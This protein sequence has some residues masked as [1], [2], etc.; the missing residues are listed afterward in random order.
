[1]EGGQPSLVSS[2]FQL[3]QVSGNDILVAF[4]DVLQSIDAEQPLAALNETTIT[5]NNGGRIEL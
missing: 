2:K 3:E 1:M 4:V 5:D